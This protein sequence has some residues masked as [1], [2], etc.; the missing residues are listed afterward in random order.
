[1][2][3]NM[4]VETFQNSKGYDSSTSAHLHWKY[5]KAIIKMKNIIEAER[6]ITLR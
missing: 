1:M 3:F 6:M 5:S 4:I 2:H